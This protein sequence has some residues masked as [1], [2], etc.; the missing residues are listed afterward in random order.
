MKNIYLTSE[1]I[2]KKDLKSCGDDI[3]NLNV[4]TI[5]KDTSESKMS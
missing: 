2:R 4:S 1:A 3:K 5:A